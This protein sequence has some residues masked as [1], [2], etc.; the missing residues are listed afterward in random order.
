[1]VLT[2]NRR[3]K[4]PAVFAARLILCAAW[5]AAAFLTG[6]CSGGEAPDRRVHLASG[7]R[8][9]T[10]DP[11]YADDL[12]SRDM[13]AAFYD[14]LLEYA[15]PDRPYRL[16]P[17][18]LAAMPEADRTFTEYRFRLRDDLYFCDDPCFGGRRRKVT[19]ADVLYSLRRLEDPATHSP[20][21]WMVRGKFES[22]RVLNDLEFT[23]RLRQADPRFLYL[24]ALPNTA[25]VP[26][27]AVERYGGDFASHPVGSGPFLLKK[28]IR[29]YRIEMVRNPDFRTQIFAAAEN[30]AD[31]KKRLPLAD[32]IVCSQIRQPFS[33]WL[34]FLQGELDASVLDKDN[35]DLAVGGGELS[36]ALAARGIRMRQAAEF[37]IRYI[38]FNCRDEKLRN[39]KLRRA[40]AMVFDVRSRVRHMSGML[41]PSAGPLP[42][43]VPG[44]DQNLRNPWQI[45]DAGRAAKMLAEAGYP[46]GIDPATGRALELSFDLGNTTSAQRQ[47]GE[48][49]Q[50]EL[51]RIGIKLE[52]SLNSRPRFVDK[53]RRGK[54]QL[55]HYSWVG[56][57]PDAEN[58]LQLFYGPNA[59]GCNRANF[60]DPAF[61]RMFEAVLPMGDTPART[62]R[63]RDMA[64]YVA[65]RTPWIFEGVPV[66]CRLHYDWLENLHP[67][68]FAFNRWKYLAVR[69]DERAARRRAFRALDFSELRGK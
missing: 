42:D 52:I 6:G 56:D 30:P 57:Y 21:R 64:A 39:V 63:Y 58:F 26:R 43:A 13:V 29:E 67:H 41:R 31:R 15:Y 11:A 47:L 3:R 61:D 48:L 7:G 2:D 66:S 28:W 14:T 69:G 33:A 22:M 36:P 8:V 55:F 34:L 49:L 19:S 25:V 24:L 40:I 50:S 20:V 37:E 54:T 16:R 18:M 35:M 65:D 46:G 5:I 51:A 9:R 17:S 44:Y 27:E 68:D 59:G 23:I 4:G 32:G 10:L 12:A 38:G 45:C 62:A 53:L 1:M 60:S